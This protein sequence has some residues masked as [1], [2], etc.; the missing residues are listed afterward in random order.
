[1]K[2]EEIKTE[3]QAAASKSSNNK[4][5]EI[6]AKVN[7]GAKKLLATVNLLGDKV[8][9]KTEKVK[10]LYVS[11]VYALALLGAFSLIHE[12]YNFLFVFEG[13]GAQYLEKIAPVAVLA[14]AALLSKIKLP[15]K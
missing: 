9:L 6:S 4:M 5:A 12:S 14:L 10:A 2:K 11:P 1:M 8:V 15:K 13:Y 3:E 7:E